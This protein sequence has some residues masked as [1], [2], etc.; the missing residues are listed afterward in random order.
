M[1][2]PTDNRP[3]SH[4]SHR[5]SI[6]DRSTS[7]AATTFNPRDGDDYNSAGVKPI[8]CHSHNDY[9][10]KRPLFDALA[11]GCTGVEA[12]VWLKEKDLFIGHTEDTMTQT[13]LQTMYIDP[14]SDILTHHN[15]QAS[16]T[17]RGVFDDDPSQS[18]VLMIDIKTD[19]SSTFEAVQSAL[20]PLRSKGWLTYFNGTAITPGP[21]IIVGSG[22]TPFDVLKSNDTYRDIFF[23]APLNKLS[24][25]DADQY[26]T[27]NSYYASANFQDAVAEWWIG[28]S[29]QVKTVHDQVAA[30]NEKGLKAR[31]YETPD[32]AGFARDNVW[33]TL[34]KEGVGMLSVDDLDAAK[35]RDWS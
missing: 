13:T 27:E 4:S 17:P 6:Y 16:D 28:T 30:A 21:L 11:A 5:R 15:E 3:Q 24:D 34:E 25:A 2:V 33:N 19:G 7:G 12:D 23:D 14:I 22:D 20:E 10:Q 35:N 32:W 8:P 31:Y 29:D 1:S 18:L 9:L 26:T